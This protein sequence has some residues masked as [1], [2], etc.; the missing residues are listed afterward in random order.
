MGLL[1]V[2]TI[3]ADNP[4]PMRHPPPPRLSGSAI[5]GNEDVSIWIFQAHPDRFDLPAELRELEMGDQSG[6]SVNQ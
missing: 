6:W 2:S 1:A 5:M 3:S 4:A